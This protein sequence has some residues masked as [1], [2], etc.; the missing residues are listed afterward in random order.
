MTEK[1][2]VKREPKKYGENFIMFFPECRN[3][4]G[5]M[6]VWATVT[7]N[8]GCGYCHCGASYEYYRACKPVDYASPKVVLF[9]TN[10]VRYIRTLP[11]MSDYAIKL[12]KRM[13]K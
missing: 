2:I 7:T 5:S 6:E 4:D 13:Q 3:T 10:Y 1:I 12:Y 8:P 9:V 11:D